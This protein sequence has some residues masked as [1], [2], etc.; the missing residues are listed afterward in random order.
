MSEERNW[1]R[2]RERL[3]LHLPVRVQGR[4]TPDFAWTEMT[5][6]N[7]E[8]RHEMTTLNEE[9]NT[10]LR[11]LHEDVISRISLLQE[12]SPKSRRKSPRRRKTR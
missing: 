11:V 5:R 2:I 12:G 7:E 3:A 6:L 10:H 9:T 4:E 8:T 1:K